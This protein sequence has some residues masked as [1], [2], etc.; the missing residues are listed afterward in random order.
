MVEKLDLDEILQKNPS[1]SKQDLA[2]NEALAEELRK[3]GM[4]R[5]GYGLASPS[6]G[7]Q[8]TSSSD[9]ASDPRTVDL[10]RCRRK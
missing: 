10:T 4:H 5:K 8:A 2:N 6:G 7:R 3:L 1:V 9:D